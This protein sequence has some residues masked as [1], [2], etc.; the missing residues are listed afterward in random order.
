MR[1]AR[2]F[3]EGRNAVVIAADRGEVDG[4]IR[5]MANLP[6]AVGRIAP[7]VSAILLSP[8]MPPHC[9][10]AFSRKGAPLAVVRLSWSTACAFRRGY[11]QDDSV[12]EMWPREATAERHGLS[13]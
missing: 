10:A 6:E 12:P 2:L 7:E 9:G 8:G 13:D 3:L 11:A 1:L 4:P 5:G